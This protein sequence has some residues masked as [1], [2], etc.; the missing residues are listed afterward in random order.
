MKDLIAELEDTIK[1]IGYRN[2]KEEGF[3]KITAAAALV[4]S[5][6]YMSLS[7]N[8]EEDA[9]VYFT[10]GSLRG[11]CEEF[12]VLSFLKHLDPEERDNAIRTTMSLKVQES[13]K[14]QMDFPA[15]TRHWLIPINT[16]LHI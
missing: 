12:I 2:L 16:L 7:A 6:E 11:I 10:L 1:T 5:Y 8:H 3:Y 4:K 15:F 13:L 9:K 14:R